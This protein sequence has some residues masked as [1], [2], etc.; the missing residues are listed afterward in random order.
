MPPG[1]AEL[2][3]GRRLEADLPLPFDDLLDLAI[4]D[5]TEFVC[6]DAAL[7]AGGTGFLEGCGTEKAAN[8]VGAE[9][10]LFSLHGVPLKVPAPSSYP[11]THTSRQPPLDPAMQQ[12]RL[13]P[14]FAESKPGSRSLA[15]YSIYAFGEFLS[16]IGIFAEGNPAPQRNFVTQGYYSTGVRLSGTRRL[17]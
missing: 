2:A 8:H 14:V 1:A 16:Y 4:L 3:V 9:W 7:G 15:V 17:S 10:R 13:V 5:C 12:L 11:R 6:G